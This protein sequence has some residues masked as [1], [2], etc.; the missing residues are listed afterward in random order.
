MTGTIYSAMSEDYLF[1]VKYGT[2]S[3]NAF[4]G[5]TIS[6][7]FFLVVGKMIQILQTRFFEIP[8]FVP[9][10]PPHGWLPRIVQLQHRKWAV[11]EFWFGTPQ[12]SRRTV[13][14]NVALAL[15]TFVAF[16]A[17]QIPRL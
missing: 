3:V 16:F 6:V 11:D 4:I 17:H 13:L 15:A 7:F 5:Y 8:V 1:E 12:R 10:L 9:G 2:F 14:W